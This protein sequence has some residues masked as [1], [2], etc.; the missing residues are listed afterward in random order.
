MRLLFIILLFSFQ[1]NG[2]V[3]FGRLVN[4][5]GS[6]T[7]PAP[8]Y[9]GDTIIFDSFDGSSLS[10]RYQVR[11]PDLQ[12]ITVSGGKLRIIGNGDFIPEYGGMFGMWQSFQ[13]NISD[14]GYGRSMIRNYKIE[15]GFKINSIAAN[16]P[17][18]WVG[19]KNLWDGYKSNA[20]A[21]IMYNAADTL[22]VCGYEDTTYWP[23]VAPRLATGLPDIN[24]VDNY[25]L[26]LEINE[27]IAK[28]KLI[29][30]SQSDSAEITQPFTMYPAGIWPLR[31]NEF[32]YSFGVMG[33]SDISFD[34]FIV[35]TTEKKNPWAI[36][37]GNSITTGYAA[38][39]S[40]SAFANRLKNNTD[41]TIQIMAGAGATVLTTIDCL[42]ELLRFDPSYY[43]INLGTNS[44]GTTA[45]YDRLTDSLETKGTVIHTLTVNGGD[46]AT[47]GTWNNH[48]STTYPSTY[49]DTWTT[50]WSTMSIGNGEM[51]DALHPTNS[52]NRKI[53][54]IIKA[55]K[56]T[57]FP[58]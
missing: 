25:R 40:D 30:V 19:T 56:P 26:I 20:F 39:V 58:L 38:S 6:P 24:T 52:G 55:A 48:I 45:D 10:A 16:T 3:Y 7:P 53:A 43:F 5:G 15:T 8:A 2:Q 54:N 28:A 50:G 57:L 27:D 47:G 1:A 32:F 14:T 33:K 51:A 21:H 34:Y 42:P 12:T 4:R 36:F 13:L 37:I 11:R 9:S 44:G 41:S 29:N 18:L 49:I 46:P 31:P 23:N 35:T 17:G 22:T